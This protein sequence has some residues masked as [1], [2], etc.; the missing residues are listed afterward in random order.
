M[1][2]P[3]WT[4][5]AL[6]SEA[7]PL[8]GKMLA[9]GRSA[10]P[11][12]HAETGRHAGRASAARRPYRGNE[13]GHPCRMPAS[14]LSAGHAIPLRFDLSQRL[15]F[16]SR[17]QDEGRLL[18]RRSRR[19]G[20]RRN[21]VLPA[22]LLCRF[23]R[24]ALAEGCR[25]IHGLLG[26]RFRTGRAIDLTKPP[27][28]SDSALWT[29]LL[30]LRGLSGTCRRRA[31]RR[32]WRRSGTSR[33]AIPA[34]A[35]MSPC[36]P[37]APS[38]NRNPVERQTWRVRLNAFG[39]PGDL[40]IPGQTHRLRPVG[41]RRRP[42]HRLA[43]VGTESLKISAPVCFSSIAARLTYAPR[44]WINERRRRPAPFVWHAAAITRPRP[45]APA[46]SSS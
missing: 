16:S 30:R 39:R 1:S 3:I 8:E 42:A 43:A 13:A 36:F 32:N 17:W 31:A 40:R 14:R 27:L 4:P 37:A 46:W 25:R 6:S 26:C 12:F 19:H 28:S 18:R 44:P 41:L 34:S 5:A 45:S 10:A 11:G 21:G 15:A 29:R 9:A 22:A 23:A 24:H 33:C 20:G 2:S 35:P 38:Q 7:V